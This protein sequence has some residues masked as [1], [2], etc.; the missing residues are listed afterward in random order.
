LT[1]RTGQ[2]SFFIHNIPAH[3]I[4]KPKL[5]GKM[6]VPCLIC[7]KNQTLNKMREHVGAH[8]L[9]ALRHVNS[10]VLLLLNMEIGIEPCGFCGLDGCIT[11]LSVSKEG[12]HSIKSSCQYHYEKIQYKAA[13]ATSNRSPCTNVSLHC[14]LC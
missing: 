14:S 9:L 6:S 4:P 12:K 2:K 8:I 1:H 3:L 13:K 7:G 5:P 11:Q 10:G